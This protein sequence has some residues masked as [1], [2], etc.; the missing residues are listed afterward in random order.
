MLEGNRASFEF[1]HRGCSFSIFE[2]TSDKNIWSCQPK[3]E[4]AWQWWLQGDLQR[5]N[6]KVWELWRENWEDVCGPDWWEQNED[7]WLIWHVQPHIHIPRSRWKDAR[8][9]WKLLF[10]HDPGSRHSVHVRMLAILGSEITKGPGGAAEVFFF[11]L[12]YVFPASVSTFSKLLKPYQEHCICH[13][14]WFG[15]VLVQ[16]ITVRNR[17]GVIS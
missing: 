6:T 14:N 3:S 7:V 2:W 12:P 15:C 8:Q 1:W 9:V 4:E 13:F 10:T 5:D 17:P 11:C 16:T